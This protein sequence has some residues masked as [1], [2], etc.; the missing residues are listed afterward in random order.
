MSKFLNISTDT[1]LG[2]NSPSDETVSSQK[3]LKT[4]I[5]AHSSGS[6]SWG[7]ITG[8]L[9]NQTDLQNELNNKA[10][11]SAVMKLTGNQTAAG[12]KTFTNGIVSNASIG[13]NNSSVLLRQ[14]S[15]YYYF[16]D[17]TDLATSE[18]TPDAV[19][20][21]IMIAR[22]NNGDNLGQ[23]LW[24]Q[25]TGGEYFT[26]L[27]V[28]RKVN[29]TEKSAS[30]RVAINSS[31]VAYTS[32]PNPTLDT[33][34]ST[35]IDT[36]GAR[37]TK[38]QDY[39]P[40]SSLSTCHVVIE[41]YVNGSSWYRI[42][43]DGWC[44]QGGQVSYLDGTGFRTVTYL[45]PFLNEPNVVVTQKGSYYA[46][47]YSGQHT[48]NVQVSTATYCTIYVDSNIPYRNWQACGYIS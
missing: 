32:A 40:T 24:C 46:S 11:D 45:K 20:Y 21:E 48:D 4:Y 25:T 18:T 3:A 1:T 19:K 28:H 15:N 6:P 39:V 42:Y 27:S 14:G 30:L 35:E 47:T 17:R 23:L 13:V 16:L 2:G 31:G 8:T 43:D 9:S 29:G 44:E 33:T 10:D 41:T 7:S 38:L 26:D 34:S 37:N 12:V 36:V 5:D 22:A